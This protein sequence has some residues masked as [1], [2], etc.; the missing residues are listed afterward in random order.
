MPGGRPRVWVVGEPRRLSALASPLRIELVGILQTLG[1]SSIRQLA[2]E[3]DRSPDSL[4]HHV[5]LLLKAGVLLETAR[6]KAGRRVEAVYS[7]T[8]PRIGG[9]LDQ[10]PRGKAPVVRAGTAALRLAAREFTTAI[11][12]DAVTCTD[13]VANTRASR[14]RTWLTDEGLS[15]LHRLLRQIERLLARENQRKEGRLHSLTIVLAPL[16]K[17]R[18]RKNA[19]P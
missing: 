7:L 19:S 5:R 14:Q 12:A 10:S 17:T 13:G 9:H 16:N 11:E 6:R 3:L 18:K 2:S 1:P 15:R 4:Y 8:A